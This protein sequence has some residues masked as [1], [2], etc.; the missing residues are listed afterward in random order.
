M[1]IEF[2]VTPSLTESGDIMVTTEANFGALLDGALGDQYQRVTTQLVHLQDEAVR[3]G[4]MAL[5]WIPPLDGVDRAPTAPNPDVGIQM[6]SLWPVL[7]RVDLGV[8][9]EA[10]R[11]RGWVRV[12]NRIWEEIE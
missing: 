3:N 5:G 10:L 4:L 8:L 2:N 11:M 12:R 1:N 7:R 9:R 6:A